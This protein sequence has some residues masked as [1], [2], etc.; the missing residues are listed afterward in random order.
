MS[1]KQKRPKPPVHAWDHF[2]FRPELT[3]Q[4]CSIDWDWQNDKEPR[5]ECVPRWH[6]YI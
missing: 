1:K 4:V 2:G 5:G 6:V 3:C